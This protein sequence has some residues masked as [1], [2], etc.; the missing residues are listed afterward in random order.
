MEHANSSKDNNKKKLLLHICCAP[1]STS[2]ILQLSPEY[3]AYGF[4]YNP[5]IDIEQEYKYRKSEMKKIANIYN[6][7][8]IYGE[9]DVEKWRE[10]VKGL[11]DEP[12]GARR[13]EVCFRKRLKKTAQVAMKKGFDLFCTTLTVSPLKNANLINRIGKE[14]E[15]ETGCIYLESNF[16]KKDGFKKSVELS[17]K[18]NLYR[19]D[20]CGCSFSKREVGV[21]RREK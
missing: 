18:Y 1:C 12:E 20:Y 17:K 16:K 11:E 8:V 10:S 21:G 15:Q 14:I 19:Q 6:V 13:C 7:P 9:Y 2:V 5:N 4:F 3:D